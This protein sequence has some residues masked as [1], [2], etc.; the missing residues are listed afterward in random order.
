MPIA[1][2]LDPRDSAVSHLPAE[3]GLISGSVI[4]VVTA[5]AVPN[6]DYTRSP[7]SITSSTST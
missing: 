6:E 7:A 1:A 5:S 4:H 2:E 3:V